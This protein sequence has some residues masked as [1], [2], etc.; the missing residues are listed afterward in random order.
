M[1]Q[2]RYAHG[3]ADIAQG[4]YTHITACLIQRTGQTEINVEAILEQYFEQVYQKILP[5]AAL[6]P[7]PNVSG[8][9]ILIA[10]G[11]INPE[12]YQYV[13]HVGGSRNIYQ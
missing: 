4:V 12:V 8:V 13:D 11:I 9:R 1:K 3:Y 2:I 10:N 5:L 6:F 7:L